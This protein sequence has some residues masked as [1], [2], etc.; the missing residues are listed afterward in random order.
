MRSENWKWMIGVAALGTICGL[1]GGTA[2]PR[3]GTADR[4]G[5]HAATA[6]G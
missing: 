1:H 2:L 4:D 3:A 5:I 6:S